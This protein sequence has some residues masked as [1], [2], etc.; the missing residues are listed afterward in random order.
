MV[1][2]VHYCFLICLHFSIGCDSR[3]GFLD[4][5]PVSSSAKFR[6][7]LLSMCSDAPESTTNYLSSDF[8]K[9]GAGNDKTSEG[10]L[11]VAVSFSLSV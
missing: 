2:D 4:A 11:N 5:R 7:F 8:V 9:V 6:S 1:V 3:C 10:E